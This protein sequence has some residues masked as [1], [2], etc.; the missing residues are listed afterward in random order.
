MYVGVGVVVVASKWDL[1][2]NPEWK[3]KFVEAVR[4]DLPFIDYAPVVKT[5]AKNSSAVP[6]R[7]GS[8]SSS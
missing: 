4:H 3:E 1:V 8:G 5:S 2:E 6:M 7:S